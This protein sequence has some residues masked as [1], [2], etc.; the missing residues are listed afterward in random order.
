M[1]VNE[2]LDGRAVVI[3]GYTMAGEPALI[4]DARLFRLHY[5]D[6]DSIIWL[7]YDDAPKANKTSLG[8][9]REAP[10]Y[11]ASQ[12]YRKPDYSAFI[13]RIS[14]VVS[15]RTIPADNAERQR[16]HGGKSNVDRY[17]APKSGIQR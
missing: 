6:D 7:T 3:H 13:N 5:T 14:D 4:D 9:R 1:I 12:H 10:A 2:I 11:D 16:Q 17:H 15:T 8:D